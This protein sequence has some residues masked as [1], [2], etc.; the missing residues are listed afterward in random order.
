MPGILGERAV[1]TP[2]G[3]ACVDEPRIVPAAVLGADAEAL[4]DARPEALD[5]HIGSGGQRPY[6]R[7]SLGLLEIGEDRPAAASHD[8]GRVLRAEP[9]R[10]AKGPLD[11]H[12]VGAEI[13]QHHGRVRS[14]PESREFEDA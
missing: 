10:P 6:Q 2:A 9:Q 4:G 8:V 13:G 11:A 3:D 14:R 7:T 5:Q 1:L 12:H